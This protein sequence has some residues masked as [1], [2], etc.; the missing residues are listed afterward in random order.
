V[1][2]SAPDQA[3]ALA[4][5]WRVTRPGGELRFYEHVVAQRPVAAGLQR[6]ADATFWPAS[7][8]AGTLARH[9][10]ADDLSDLAANGDMAARQRFHAGLRAGAGD[11][12]RDHLERL[13][14]TRSAIS[15][16]TSPS[17]TAM[18]RW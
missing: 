11:R 13:S 9:T 16:R 3:R 7:A 4:E 2:C 15:A 6:I 1:L 8:A 14:S 12:L 18:P 10:G 17:R 5:F